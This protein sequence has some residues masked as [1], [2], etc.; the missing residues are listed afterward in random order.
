MTGAVCP[1][2]GVAVTPGY[3]RCPKCKRGLPQRART[4]LEGG[5]AVASSGRPIRWIILGA[6]VA[7]LVFIK[8][9]AIPAFEDYRN[10]KPRMRLPLLL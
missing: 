3:V 2:C 9:V 6:L 4:A 7:A 5:T 1:S 10:V 8:W